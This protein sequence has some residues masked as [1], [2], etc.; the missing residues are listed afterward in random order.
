MG[1]LEL[2]IGADLVRGFGWW[3]I[4]SFLGLLFFA[5]KG[6]AS[7]AGK[8]WWTFVVLAVF[9]GPFVPS[10]IRQAQ[11]E[12]KQKIAKAV[13]EERCKSAGE[14]IR[15]TVTNVDG[16]YLLNL[17]PDS[18]MSDQFDPNDPAGDSARGEG[19]I[20]TFFMG[21]GHNKDAPARLS[22][23]NREGAYTFV[24]TPSMNGTGVIRY[25][26][27]RIYEMGELKGAGILT[28]RP[29]SQR[30][31]RYGVEWTDISTPG[32]RAHWIAGSRLRVIDLD[33]GEVLGERLAYMV[34]LGLGNHSGFRTPW[35]FARRNA[36][37]P[38]P[39]AHTSRPDAWGVTRYFVEK[40][41]QPHGPTR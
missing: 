8:I 7:L 20:E 12:R 10:V 19:Y 26:D 17:R 4:A 14:F 37:P 36:C 11:F 6:P 23:T 38:F 27:Q 3:L 21:R 1:L 28:A 29:S 24:E 41:V 9:I 34:D 31:A 32:D 2:G 5:I 30:Q 15:K 40:I 18:S 33:T 25:S 35:L 13:F 22:Y 39:D 16:I